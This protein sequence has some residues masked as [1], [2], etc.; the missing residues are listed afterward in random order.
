MINRLV[1]LPLASSSERWSLRPP[2]MLKRAAGFLPL[3]VAEPEWP[4]QDATLGD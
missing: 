4:P 2:R 3:R 1:G